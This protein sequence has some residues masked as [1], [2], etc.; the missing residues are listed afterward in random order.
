MVDP[1]TI[2][3]IAIYIGVSSLGTLMSA[4]TVPAS[5]AGRQ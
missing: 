3:K 4:S 2:S 5:L 1:Y